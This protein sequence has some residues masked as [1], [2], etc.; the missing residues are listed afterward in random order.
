MPGRLSG[1]NR[2]KVLVSA[3]YIIP[4]LD[5]F[6]GLFAQAGIQL[7]VAEVQERLSAEQL[8][9]YAGA[10][11]GVICGD[12]EF[13]AEVLE[14]FSP[15][16]RVISKWG[17]GI[18]SIDWQTASR[19]GISVRNT[20]D[21]FI[22]PV[23]DSVLGYILSFARG[24]TAMDRKMKAGEWD[25]TPGWALHEQTLGV[26]GVGRIG[27]RIVEK[28]AAFGIT[29]LGND[30]VEIDPA[31]IGKH[32]LAMLRLE[33][34]LARS[35]YVSLSVDLNP[36]SYHMMNAE[37]LALMKPSSVLINAARGRVVDE[38][39]LVEALRGGRLR[40]AAMDVF[41]EEPLPAD[42]PLRGFDNVMLAPHNANASPAA[43]ARVHRTTIRHL[44]EEL[45]IEVPPD[46]AEQGSPR[47]ERP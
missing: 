37:T 11:D 5:Q 31:F 23:S 18:D 27:R 38:P 36:S 2:M 19:L 30:I 33:N 8:R 42:S 34:L 17:T 25:K 6:K 4:D 41:E 26:V 22:E 14:A 29:L 3:P 20:A 13:S 47:E 43:W 7:V 24:L 1:K 28:S 35:D 45:D 15:R 16:L 21:A 39:A 10:V 9:P 40:G 44:L 46:L 12:D 32:G